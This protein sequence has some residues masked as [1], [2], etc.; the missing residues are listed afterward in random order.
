QPP[1][2]P[3][4]GTMSED[5]N[6]FPHGFRKVAEITMGQETFEVAQ[7]PCKRCRDAVFLVFRFERRVVS[8][9]ADAVGLDVVGNEPVGKPHICFKAGV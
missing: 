4:G 3:D 2:C 9:A 5:V 1:P 6:D 7:G 8:N